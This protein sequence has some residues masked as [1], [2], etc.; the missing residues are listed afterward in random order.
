ML[1]SRQSRLGVAP[2]RR[3]IRID[4]RS[5]PVRIGA[6][7]HLPRLGWGTAGGRWGRIEAMLQ[8]HLVESGIPVVVYD[9]APAPADH[10]A[11]EAGNTLRFRTMTR[12]TRR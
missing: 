7:V 4:P 12:M 2:R 5:E 6:S 11:A 8:R 10:R 1:W 3:L 9:Y